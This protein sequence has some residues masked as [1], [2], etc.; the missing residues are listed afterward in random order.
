HVE[1][2]LVVADGRSEDSVRALDAVEIELALACKDI[3]YLAKVHQVPAVID[4][5]SR[6]V[7]ERTDHE[8]VVLAHATDARIGARSRNDRIFVGHSR[9]VLRLRFGGS[10]TRIFLDSGRAR[11]VRRLTRRGRT[12]CNHG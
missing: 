4:G 9:A 1:G 11:G 5:D 12:R 7:L 8:V 6:E 2:A 3:A 10:G